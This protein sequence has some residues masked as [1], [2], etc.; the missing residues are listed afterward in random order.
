MY[1]DFTALNCELIGL[2]I[3]GLN[4]IQKKI[5][6]KGT[7]DTEIKFPVIED[8]TTEV[9]RKYGMIQ[10][11][12]HTVSAVRAVFFIDP[13]CMIKGVNYYPM[14]LGLNF[15]ELKRVIV[16][17]QT[18]DEAIL[19]PA[20]SSRI[21]KEFM[22]PKTE[23]KKRNEWYLCTSELSEEKVMNVN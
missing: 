7:E 19:P 15:D 12:K 20:Q 18:G 21:D 6:H 23:G 3:N 13:E 2:P 4:S 10:P 9:T 14:S 8:I 1:A 16:A 5:E 22:V 11:D 17:L